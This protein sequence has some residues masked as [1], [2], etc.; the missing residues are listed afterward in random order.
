MSSIQ[1]LS[2]VRR[3]LNLGLPVVALESA[4]ITHGLP[5]PSHLSLA[6][7]AE[8]IVRQNGATPATI[9]ILK[10][11]VHIGLNPVELERL[12]QKS[13]ETLKISRRDIAVAILKQANGGTT[14]AGT[15]FL[16]HKAGIQV[17][18]TGGIGGV[19]RGMVFDISADLYAL[20]DTPMLVVCAGAKAILDL[21]ATLERLESLSVPVVGYQTNEFPA[22]YSRESGLPVNIRLD[23]VEDIVEF[24][25]AHWQLGMQS[26]VLVVQPPPEEEAIPGI[27]VEKWIEQ[28]NREAALKGV[29]GPQLTP[30]LLQ[31]VDE[32]SSGRALRANLALLRQNAA[33]AARIASALALRNRTHI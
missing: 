1:V 5:A 26:A 19:H 14:V 13:T 23:Q 30:Y 4:V 10:G 33:L 16:A 25:L 3:A 15:M 9:A 24:A 2:E 21:Q 28:A 12:A 20:S 18:A 22:F 29:R 6:Q 27:E 8:T 32:L 11:Q 17:F 31:R 7:D